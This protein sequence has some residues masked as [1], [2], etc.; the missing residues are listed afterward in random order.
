MIFWFYKS[1][2]SPSK[3]RNKDKPAPMKFSKASKLCPTFNSVFENGEEKKCTFPNCQFQ[4]DPAKYLDSKLPDISENCHVFQ[5][6]GIC[7]SGLSCRLV[8]P[9]LSMD[10]SITWQGTFMRIF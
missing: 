5:T 3:G 1:F 8:W 9:H 6:Y 4:D 7:E 2:Y 10:S